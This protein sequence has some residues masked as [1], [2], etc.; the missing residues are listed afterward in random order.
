MCSGFAPAPTTVG[1]SSIEA[2]LGVVWVMSR[3]A[4]GAPGAT[5]LRG[6][7][8]PPHRF[9][10]DA[11]RATYDDLPTSGGGPYKPSQRR[12]GQQRGADGLVRR[13]RGAVRS[14]GTMYFT[15]HQHAINTVWRWAGL[16]YDGPIAT[17]CGG[18]RTARTRSWP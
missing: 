18:W 15:W 7:R 3:G 17:G 11:S 6:V 14:K 1:P 16:R 9:A 2:D 12:S 4:V 8:G 5:V 10:L 13:Q